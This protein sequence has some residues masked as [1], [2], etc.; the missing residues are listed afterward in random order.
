MDYDYLSSIVSNYS[1]LTSLSTLGGSALG[2]ST[3]L[4]GVSSLLNSGSALDSLDNTSSLV[5][6]N[7]FSAILEAAMKAGR[8]GDDAGDTASGNLSSVAEIATGLLTKATEGDSTDVATNL[9]DE[10]AQKLVGIAG[11]GTDAA[12]E[13][14]ARSNMILQNYLYTAMMKD[15]LEN[16]LTEKADFTS[17]LFSELAV[18][19]EDEDG[20]SALSS[21]KDST[22]GA[23][24]N[25]SSYKTLLDN[26]NLDELADDVV[27]SYDGQGSLLR[28]MLSSLSSELKNTS[29]SEATQEHNRS[30]DSH[31]R[32]RS[33]SYRRA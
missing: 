16:S 20:T 24:G 7:T 1:N 8:T 17:G 10:A 29:A 25:Y 4:K 2:G 11:A 13:G 14:E 5:G 21:L 3:A 15:S 33:A 6:A 9:S 19:G 31:L 22:L 23:I 32:L 18:G 30:F 26:T 27:S 28:E 12:F